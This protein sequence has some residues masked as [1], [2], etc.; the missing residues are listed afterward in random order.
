MAANP[1]QIPHVFQNA[2][3]H[4]I[5][6]GDVA[7]VGVPRDISVKAAT[8]SQSAI[9]PLPP[10]RLPEASEQ[11]ISDAA[12]ILNAAKKVAIYAGMEAADCLSALN[13]AADI[14]AAPIITSYKS[15]MALTR[16]CTNYVGHLAYLDHWSAVESI[17]NADAVLILGTN[18]PYPG[19]F[20]KGRPTIQVDV[21]A[22]RIGKV[23]DATLGVRAYAGLFLSVL[24]KRLNRKTDREFLTRALA[25]YAKILEKLRL[26]TQNTG[27]L[28]AI[29]PEYFF[30]LLEKM[31]DEDCVFTVDTGLNNLWSSHY[32]TPGKYRAMIGSFMHGS[33][34]N[35]IPQSI[36]VA[37]TRSARK[38]IALC[39]D[40]GLATL[41]GDL[42]TIV[43]YRLPIKI[44]VGNNR[45]LGLVKWE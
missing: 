37:L 30:S 44:F 33:V 15:R 1:E 40:D 35:A 32:L 2:M 5:S 19:F 8:G 39:G 24:N 22:E 21:R 11:E 18:F 26:P 42:M 17:A 28:G 4:A 16:D 3:Q 25:D 23:A 10:V 13:E 27:S 12:E 29:R 41:F 31:A 45:C 7:V 9:T 6:R 38:I 36:G 43:Q 20:P 34:G 14:L